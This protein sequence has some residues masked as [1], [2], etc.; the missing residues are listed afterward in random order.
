MGEALEAVHNKKMSIR[1]ASRTFHVPLTTLSDRVSGRVTRE[2][3]GPDPVLT[4]AEESRLAEWILSMNN[5]GHGPTRVQI[6][7]TVKQILDMNKRSNPF[8]DNLP[9]RGWYASFLKRH[10]EV[11]ESYR[12]STSSSTPTSRKK[13]DKWFKEY[14]ET[15][16]RLGIG[17]KPH[18]IW[19]CGELILPLEPD[20]EWATNSVSGLFQGEKGG[21]KRN[22]KSI[23]TLCAISAAGAVMPPSH[24][25]QKLHRNSGDGVP[26]TFY[27]HH[28]LGRMDPQLFQVWL[29]GHFTE[30]APSERPILILF[31]GL[32][33]FID[34]AT[35]AVALENEIELMCLPPHLV[36][37]PINEGLFTSLKIDWLRNVEDFKSEK[38]QKKT[39][40]K[41]FS[42]LFRK[43]WEDSVRLCNI[44]D[45]FR[46]TG[47]FPQ[48]RDLV[49]ISQKQLAP[50]VSSYNTIPNLLVSKM[51]VLKT[52]EESMPA[53]QV[54]LFEKRFSRGFQSPDPLYSTWRNL[55]LQVH[56]PT[57]EES[58]SSS[59]SSSSSDE[60]SCSDD[61][62]GDTEGGALEIITPVVPQ[63][64]ETAAYEEVQS[65]SYHSV[66][67]IKRRR[68]E[69]QSSRC[70]EEA[71]SNGHIGRFEPENVEG[72]Y[73][74]MIDKDG[75]TD[76]T[77]VAVSVSP[78]VAQVEA[79]QV[80][81]ES[82]LMSNQSVSSNENVTMET[83]SNSL[84]PHDTNATSFQPSA[85]KQAED[86][87]ISLEL[88]E[89]K[90][91][92]Q[93]MYNGRSQAA[94]IPVMEPSPIQLG[95]T[96]EIKQNGRL[97]FSN[98][99]TSSI[100]ATENEA[101]SALVTVSMV[102]PASLKGLDGSFDVASAVEV[103]S[104]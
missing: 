57:E 6:C 74:K 38:Q 50:K 66:I 100:T 41:H 28:A 56:L 70:G 97:H 95:G 81:D 58:E 14:Q 47:V 64:I 90:S 15:V 60:D 22:K 34:R 62:G 40:I 86:L 33:S 53:I 80:S 52:L 89:E 26:C 42:S 2:T 88:Q 25:F 75:A 13:L 23:S 68:K 101:V 4:K 21:S 54:D 96:S 98:S 32:F 35:K 24:L 94:M 31:D 10:P 59:E 20:M 85:A 9:G 51:A 55:R 71:S 99:V 16:D 79:A 49:G 44:F 76:L 91:P 45:G 103:E 92:K 46:N 77:P 5:I 61:E 8:I 43:T 37:Q 12:S 1:Q 84:S 83:D 69:A 93:E 72:R 65:Q 17:S 104:S 11:R 78:S 39:R 18:L 27:M 3:P 87:Q 67:Q 102:D 63:N 7:E 73:I 29:T 48:N 82:H 19:N 36:Q 30:H